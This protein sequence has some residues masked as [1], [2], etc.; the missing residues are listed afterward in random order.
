MVSR[1]LENLEIRDGR[2]YIDKITSLVVL[3]ALD[4]VVA[5][6]VLVVVVVSVLV[7]LLSLLLIRTVTTSMSEMAENRISPSSRVLMRVIT[8]LIATGLMDSLEFQVDSLLLLLLLL[9]L[10]LLPLSGFEV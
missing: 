6:S 5:T 1:P 4:L 3:T 7:S 2:T 10:L 9:F 8:R